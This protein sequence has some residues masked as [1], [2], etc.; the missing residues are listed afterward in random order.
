MSKAA[1][2]LTP[3]GIDINRLFDLMNWV[4]EQGGQT[5]SERSRILDCLHGITISLRELGLQVQALADGR[6][7]SEAQRIY[8]ALCSD[9]AMVYEGMAEQVNRP[10]DNWT[11]FRINGLSQQGRFGEMKPVRAIKDNLTAV[12][13]ELRTMTHRN[14]YHLQQKFLA[15]LPPCL[16]QLAAQMHQ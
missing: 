10:N 12:Q 13:K 14:S 8:T 4:D 5:L 7:R 3:D 9:L 1:M 15:D 16:R 2:A 11:S 6:P